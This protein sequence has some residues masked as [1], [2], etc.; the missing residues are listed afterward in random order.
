MKRIELFFKNALLRILIFFNPVKKENTVP[1]FNSKSTIL[2]IRLNRIGDALVTTPL[3]HEIKKQICCKIIILADRKNHFIFSNNSSIDEV[4]VF[5]KGFRGITGINNIISEKKI[6]VIVDLHDDVSTT[7][8]FLIALAKVKYKFGLLRSNHTIYTHTVEKLNPVT[9][10]IV[11]RIFEIGKLFNI[12]QKKDEVSVKYFP[13]DQDILDADSVLATLNPQNN[14]LV[15]INISAGSSA[16]FWGV[17]NYRMIFDLLSQY[18]IKTIL[19]CTELDYHLA[20][21]ISKE[22]NIYPP[23]KIFGNFATAIMKLSFLIT[24][25]TSIVHIASIKKIPVFGIYVKYNTDDM[26]WSPYNTEFECVITKESTLKNIKFEEVKNKLI[27]FLEK[28]LN[29]KTNSRL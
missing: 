19:F 17:E 20:K 26:I 22:V 25:D 8:S 12:K 1:S 29:V 16:R 23:T 11:D 7:V 6:D 27:P 5:K 24:P 10:H 2:F 14:F 4:I 18:D 15:G 28:K 21:Q 3:L 9:N 13:S